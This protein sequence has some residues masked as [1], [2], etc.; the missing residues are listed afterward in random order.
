MGG[1]DVG[2]EGASQPNFID[3]RESGVFHQQ[4]DA[5]FQSCFG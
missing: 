3:S 5:R 1:V 2:P 4:V